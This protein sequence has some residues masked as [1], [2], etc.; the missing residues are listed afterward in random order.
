MSTN[1]PEHYAHLKGLMGQL[2]Q[3]IPGTMS[4]FSKLHSGAVQDG[5]LDT[6]TKELIALSIAVTVRCD[7]CIAF[8]VHDALVAGATREEI[9]EA[10]GVAVLMGGGPA[11]MYG[12]EALEALEQFEA[13]GVA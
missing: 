6:K 12:A 4:G 5:A 10:I 2:H 11:V 3:E 1:Y 9:V 7:G 13:E 8:H